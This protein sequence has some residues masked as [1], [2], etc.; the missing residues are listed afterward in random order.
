MKVLKKSEIIGRDLVR[1][2]FTEKNILREFNCDFIIKLH[3]AFQTSEKLVMVIDYCPRGDLGE[4]IRYERRFSEQRS[5][6]YLA[7]IIIAIE[8]LHE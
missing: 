5:R 7:E 3:Y 2:A 4:H 1:Y 6:V 8:Y